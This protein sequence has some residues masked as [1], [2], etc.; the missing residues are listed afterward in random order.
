MGPSPAKLI[1]GNDPDPLPDQAKAQWE[2]KYTRAARA[3]IEAETALGLTEDAE[4]ATYSGYV[5]ERRLHAAQRLRTNRCLA[6]RPI[7]SVAF[8]PGFADLRYFNRTSAD[9]TTRRPRRRSSSEL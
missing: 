5:L 4:S 9:A 7:A 1:L 6:N 3:T 8:D 2:Q